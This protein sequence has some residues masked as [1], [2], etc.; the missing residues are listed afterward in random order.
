MLVLGIET[1]CDETAAAVVRDGCEVLSNVIYSQIARHQVFGGVV[2][3]IASR[4]HVEVLPR[5]IGEAM[6]NAGVAWTDIDA[7]AATRGPGLSTSLLVGFTAA[8]ALALRINKPLLGINHLEAHLYSIFLN[9]DFRPQS[10]VVCPLLILL[11]SGGHTALSI[12]RAPGKIEI[13][14]QALDDAAGEALDKGAKLLGLGYPGGPAIEL[15]AQNGN[16][17]AIKF[18]RGLAGRGSEPAMRYAFS[19]SGLKTALLYLLKSSPLD[20][21]GATSR[22]PD[23]LVS[24]RLQDLAASYQEAVVDAL[25]ARMERALGDFAIRAIACAGGVARNSRLREKLERLAAQRNLPLLLAAP[26][27]CTDNAAMIAALASAE[28][29]CAR[30]LATNLDVDP[31]WPLA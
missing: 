12:F 11:A 23:G 21:G 20:G 17:G 7:I 31:T 8:K 19:F 16:P 18:P 2:P 28:A 4:A 13:L 6:T 29:D 14:G 5:I 26:E 9:S 1:S 10:P 25:V 30:H 24:A 27:F 3:E 15:A 22:R